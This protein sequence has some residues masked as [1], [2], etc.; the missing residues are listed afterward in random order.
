MPARAM[1]L[2]SIGMVKV[3]SL[4]TT[5]NYLLL[6]SVTTSA[7]SMTSYTI[8]VDDETWKAFKSK[9]DRNITINQHIVGLIEDDINE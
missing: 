3:L 5:E 7:S 4:L 8:H 2:P 6:S 1:P 9:V